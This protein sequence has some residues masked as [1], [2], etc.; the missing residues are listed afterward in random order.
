MA[1]EIT[2]YTP[3]DYRNNTRITY[4]P[5]QYNYFNAAVAM[6]AVRASAMSQRVVSNL[7]CFPPY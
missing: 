2:P 1:H 5:T 3:H 4:D 7:M 6:N